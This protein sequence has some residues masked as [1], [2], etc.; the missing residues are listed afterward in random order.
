[1]TAKD[2]HGRKWSRRQYLT[3]T[4][5]GV[6]GIGGV[7]SLSGVGSATDDD[8]AT[9]YETVVDIVDAGADPTGSESITSVLRNHVGDDTLI[10][11]PEGRYY[12]DEQLRFT[13]F[14]N[15]GFVG[16]GA[17]I[18]PANYHEFDGPQYR[19]FRL[20][21]SERPG[22]NLRFEGFDIDQTAAETGI[23]VINAE[24]EDGLLVRNVRVHGVHDSG[25]WGPGLFNVTDPDG[26]GLIDCFHAPDGAVHVDETPN[27]GN[28]WRGATGFGIN[29]HHRGTL[30]FE[31]CI[32]GGFPDNGLYASNDTGRIGVDGG[33]YQNSGTASIRLSGTTGAIRNA[34]LTVD[35]DPHD[36]AGQHAIRLDRGEEFSIEGVEIDVPEPNGDAIRV[37]NPVDETTISNTE[38]SIGAQ[39]NNGIRL[40]P[41]TGPAVIDDVAVDIDGS[42][43][44][45]RLLGSDGGAVEVSDLRV[46][47]D[48]PGSTLRHAIFCERHAC[49][50]T[51]LDVEQHGTTR[52]R[53][54]ELRGSD[55]RL[56]DS[57]FETTDTPI[58]LNG[59]SDVTVENCSAAPTADAYSLRITSDSGGVQLSANDF[60]AGV[61]DD[62]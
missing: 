56:A 26:D 61:R 14:E 12:M 42:A 58:V 18:V 55:Y 36:S 34:T 46:T 16:D 29:Q 13:G 37:M 19:L 23:R 51:G 52:R 45:L 47:G 33:H 17:T 49:T 3:G 39:P 1:M 28:M 11:F 4:V 10:E 9:Q 2:T 7:L 35:D 8:L 62:R 5:A 15:V 32:L 54:I 20:G 22:R 41:E 27:A 50:F 48:A 57:E 31:N 24:V 21:T 30:V 38:I 44:A 53:G 6:A 59:A 43:N 60:P 40:D 25:T